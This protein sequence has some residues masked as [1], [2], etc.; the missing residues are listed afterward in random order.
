MTLLT[1][2]LGPTPLEVVVGGVTLPTSKVGPVSIK[3]GRGRHTDQPDAATCSFTC[4]SNAFAKLPGVGGWVTV[5]LGASAQAA[6]GLSGDAATWADI[7]PRFSGRIT[8]LVVGPSAGGLGLGLLTITAVGQAADLGRMRVGRGPYPAENDGARVSRILNDAKAQGSPITTGL[9]DPGQ[10]PLL[11]RA[12]DPAA[13]WGL[14]TDVAQQAGGVI[15]EARDGKVTYHD[16]EH[17]RGTTTPLDLTAANVLRQLVWQSDLDGVVNDLTLS[18][19][20]GST[21]ATVRVV[22]SASVNR[23]GTLE[24]SLSSQILD[25]GSAQ[26]RATDMVGRQGGPRWRAET[27]TIDLLRTTPTAT[28]VGVAGLE[29]GRMIDFSGQPSTSPWTTARLWVE[30][31]DEVIGPDGWQMTLAV[32]EHSLTGPA[33]RWVDY[34]HTLTWASTPDISWLGATGWWPGDVSKNRWVDTP[35]DLRWRGVSQDDTWQTIQV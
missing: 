9:I 8:D 29:V 13:A 19:G 31:W 16:S 25:Q 22:D 12:A 21:Q 4:H 26:A 35:A 1:D 24:A 7:R 30:G 34:P 33:P 14:L 2:A 18:Y 6:L 20:P 5:N 15:F 32:T 17:R 28:T 10:V 27:I 3:H 11:G 23:F